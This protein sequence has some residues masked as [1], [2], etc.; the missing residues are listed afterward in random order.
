MLRDELHDE[1]C[2]HSPISVHSVSGSAALHALSIEVLLA[3]APIR[4]VQ[5]L[6]HRPLVQSQRVQ[7]SCKMAQH[8]HTARA[9]AL[10]TASLAFPV[11]MLPT[12]TCLRHMQLTWW[13]RTSSM[14]RI[15]S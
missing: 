7:I 4:R 6:W 12:H 13:A 14:R 11:H 3:E 15:D 10:L 5:L 2:S 9:G 8:L 1:H